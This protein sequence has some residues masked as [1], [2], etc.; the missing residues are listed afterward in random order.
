MNPGT[1]TI[2]FV[3]LTHYCSRKSCVENIKADAA[4]VHVSFGSAHLD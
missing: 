4:L 2:V 3:A 1:G